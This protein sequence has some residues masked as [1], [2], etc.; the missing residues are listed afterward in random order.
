MRKWITPFFPFLFIYFYCFFFWFYNMPFLF[1]STLQGLHKKY[2][3]LDQ[4]ILFY[5]IRCELESRNFIFF[6]LFIYFILFFLQSYGDVGLTFW[7]LTHIAKSFYHNYWLLN[8]FFFFS[9][10]LSFF[11]MN[12]IRKHTSV[13]FF[14]LLL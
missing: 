10:F 14:P 4:R 5:C 1:Y 6:W 13:F 7:I 8:D 11:S 2:I 3:F 9:W 12:I